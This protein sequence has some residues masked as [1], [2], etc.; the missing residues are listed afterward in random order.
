MLK[1]ISK[2]K[3]TGLAFA[4][5]EVILNREEVPNVLDTSDVIKIRVAIAEKPKTPKKKNK[6]QKNQNNNQGPNN[7]NQNSLCNRDSSNCSCFPQLNCTINWWKHDFYTGCGGL[8]Y[9]FSKCYLSL[10]QDSNLIIDE[11][12][13]KF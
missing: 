5:Q 10:G 1:P 8:S 11:V 3:A 4:T 12:W 2:P 6:K 13:E 7:F 9:N